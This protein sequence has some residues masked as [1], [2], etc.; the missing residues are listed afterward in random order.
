MK[1]YL[2]AIE[3]HVPQDVVCCFHAFLE[4]C[5]IACTN[6]ITEQTIAILEDAL[7]QFYCYQAVFQMTGVWF[8]ISLL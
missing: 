6:V 4:F 8:D 3:G 1:V 5:Y 2:P 7:Q